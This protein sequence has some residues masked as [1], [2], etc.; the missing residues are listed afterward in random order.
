MGQSTQLQ[1]ILIAKRHGSVAE[2]AASYAD[3]TIHNSQTTA[4]WQCGRSKLCDAPVCST[5]QQ[6]QQQRE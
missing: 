1:M 5:Q 4:G 2:M 3:H 6:Q